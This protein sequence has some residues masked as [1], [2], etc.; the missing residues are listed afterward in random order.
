MI[1][2]FFKLSFFFALIHTR[3][4]TLQDTTQ[5]YLE[6]EIIF[7]PVKQRKI[8]TGLIFINF[9]SSKEGTQRKESGDQKQNLRGPTHTGRVGTAKK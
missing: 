7:S 1:F 5:D 6:Y 4:D 3:I 8:V 2:P 9:Y